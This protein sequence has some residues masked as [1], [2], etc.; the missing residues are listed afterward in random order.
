MKSVSTLHRSVS[1]MTDAM[2]EPKYPVTGFSFT[3]ENLYDVQEEIL[4]PEKGMMP[5]VNGFVY[6][7][8]DGK[9]YGEVE[10]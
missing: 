3:L 10:V 4:E 1:D 7:D 9:R 8:E 6:I 5:R 2:I